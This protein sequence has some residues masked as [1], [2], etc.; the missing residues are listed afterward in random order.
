IKLEVTKKAA[1]GILEQNGS[2]VSR[3]KLH[4]QDE[5]LV[6][7][8]VLNDGNPDLAAFLSD[9][10][11]LTAAE[12]EQT[13]IAEGVLDPDRYTFADY[14][15]YRRDVYAEY[16]RP[17]AVSDDVQA[18]LDEIQRTSATRYEA[19][20]QLEAYFHAMTYDT[21]CGALPA[22]V[23]DA[24]SF[25]D[26]FLFTSQR[27]YCMHYA[28]AFTLMANAMGIPC[29]YVQGY[30]V[31]RDAEGNA[32]VMQGNVHAWP[33]VY[34]DNVGWVAFEPTPGHAVSAGW[35]T[36]EYDPAALQREEPEPV[37]DE[38]EPPSEAQEEPE[39]SA[40][41]P[42]LFLIPA[43]AVLC[44]L[45]LAFLWSRL[46][47]RR[48][49]R[50]MRF[51]DRFRCLTQQ[52]LRLL[53]YL[54]FRMEEGETLAELSQRVMQSDREDIKAQLGSIPLYEA[55]LYAD[56]E[57]TADELTAAEKRHKQL[58][59]IIRKSKLRYRFLLLFRSV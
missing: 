50:R 1:P 24:E 7:C 14:E 33:E 28:T 32:L 35:R 31:Q 25:L 10:E 36:A 5:L 42:M 29:R 43:A 58:R 46:L 39:A 45:L 17:C 20:K 51:T 12:W 40:P 38:P 19:L 23:N 27:G 49:Y 16:C 34:F 26:D 3:K 18:I 6:S 9:A 52:D 13:A 44:F 57:I 15:Q 37:T 59:E 21:A 11:P 53:G 56:K 8:Y 22:S 55:V 54:G 2:I 48:K 30:H 47:A 41:D 4:Y